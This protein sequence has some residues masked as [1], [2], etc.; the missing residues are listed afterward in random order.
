M[1]LLNLYD[2]GLQEEAPVQNSGKV[3]PDGSVV[4]ERLRLVAIGLNKP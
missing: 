2:T 1:H 4:A 3:N